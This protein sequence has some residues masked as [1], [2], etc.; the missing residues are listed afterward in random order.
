MNNPLFVKVKEIVIQWIKDKEE[1]FK[2]KNIMIEIIEN[3]EDRLYAILN[4]GECMAAIVVAKPE[5]CSLSFRI[6]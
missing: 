5:F 1:Y 3:T 4:F 6:F 2:S